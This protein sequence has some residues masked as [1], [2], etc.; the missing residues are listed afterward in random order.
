MR[1]D[2]YAI[3]LSFIY[4]PTFRT[5]MQNASYKLQ[6]DFREIIY[7]VYTICLTSFTIP[8][9]LLRIKKC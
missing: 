2:I 9:A 1:L 3:G 6:N 8:K 4:M 5:I 7:F